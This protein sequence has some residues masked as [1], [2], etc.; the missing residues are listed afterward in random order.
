MNSPVQG[1]ALALNA[2][3]GVAYLRPVAIWGI[4]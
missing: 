1:L 3:I 4:P 2:N